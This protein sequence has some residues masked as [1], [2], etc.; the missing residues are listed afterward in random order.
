[1]SQKSPKGTEAALFL[2]KINLC[3][4]TWIKHNNPSPP[5]P[6]P[7]QGHPVPTAGFQAFVKEP[8]RLGSQAL[9][10][11]S[12]NP[13]VEKTGEGKENS[14]TAR[15]HGGPKE[16]AGQ[17]DPERRRCLWPPLPAG[18]RACLLLHSRLD[19]A[20]RED[21]GQR[22]CFRCRPT[23]RAPCAKEHGALPHRRPGKLPR[24]HRTRPRGCRAEAWLG[25]GSGRKE[26]A[27]PA[28][29]AGQAPP[30]WCGARRLRGGGGQSRACARGTESRRREAL[31][32]AGPARLR[33]RGTRR[34]RAPPGA[35]QGPGHRAAGL[36]KPRWRGGRAGGS[37]LGRAAPRPGAACR[38]QPC[39]GCPL[40]RPWAHK[41]LPGAPPW[42]SLPVA[43]KLMSPRQVGFTARPGSS[44]VENEPGPARRYTH[45]C[46]GRLASL[47]PG[48][49]RP[50]QGRPQLSTHPL[51]LALRERTA[52]GNLP[53]WEKRLS[54]FLPTTQT[55]QLTSQHHRLGV[56]D[57][58][59]WVAA[60]RPFRVFAAPRA[61]GLWRPRSRSPGARRTRDSGHA[62]RGA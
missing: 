46:S 5:T 59:R 31:E 21:R 51:P 54:C 22:G 27:S 36:R 55:P 3:W 28:L 16:H 20:E 45:G 7:P 19:P 40:T 53:V 11:R 61:A 6:R 47:R 34:L 18:R 60:W 29:Q 23:V 35:A 32:M 44:R 39:F 57:T 62:Q 26:A 25:A 30:G 33:P 24:G 49:S 37:S 4:S 9:G 13:P 17:T 48:T 2:A 38:V 50:A 8:F 1:M 14:A 56:L 43:A 12:L 52:Q 58:G 10:P 41:G 42:P 15:Q